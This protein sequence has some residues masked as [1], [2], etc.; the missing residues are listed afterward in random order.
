MFLDQISCGALCTPKSDI[1]HPRPCSTC[2]L[3]S[4]RL[5]S[6]KQTC[7]IFTIPAVCCDN[8]Y[9]AAWSPKEPIKMAKALTWGSLVRIWANRA[10]FIPYRDRLA[11]LKMIT[12]YSSAS[13]LVMSLM[14]CSVP[15]RVWSPLMQNC[16]WACMVWREE[17]G[18]RSH[19]WATP[20]HKHND[21]SM[22]VCQCAGLTFLRNR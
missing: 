3:Q 5:R 22:T 8:A 4:L 9:L 6:E 20:F 19:G 11:S 10:G 7:Q 12:K 18:H 14:A 2:P 16:E 17:P 13:S 15:S 1:R 21:F